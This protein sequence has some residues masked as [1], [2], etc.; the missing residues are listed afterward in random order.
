MKISGDVAS[1][2]MYVK[3]SRDED[4]TDSTIPFL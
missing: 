1:I 2:G 3:L 4:L